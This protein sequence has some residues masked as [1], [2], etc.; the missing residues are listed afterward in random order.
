MGLETSGEALK[1]DAG[2]GVDRDG[3]YRGRGCEEGV[4]SGC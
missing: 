3:V 2:V 1:W 4:G